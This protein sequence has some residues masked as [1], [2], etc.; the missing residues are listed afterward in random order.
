MALPSQSRL[1]REGEGPSQKVCKQ[2]LQDD[3]EALRLGGGIRLVSCFLMVPGR[4]LEV[5]WSPWDAAG[6]RGEW[7]GLSPPR[8]LLHLWDLEPD[9]LSSNTS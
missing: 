9:G 5:V 6:M 8:E 1:C 4:A 3:M 2:G 7:A